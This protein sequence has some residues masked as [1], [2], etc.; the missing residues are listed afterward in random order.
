M[1]WC[2]QAIRHNLNR[3]WPN[4]KKTKDVPMPQFVYQSLINVHVRLIEKKIVTLWFGA[5]RR[6]VIFLGTVDSILKRKASQRL[7]PH[8][9]QWFDELNQPIKFR[10]RWIIPHHRKQWVQLRMHT[11]SQCSPV[12]WKRKTP[13]QWI[14][15]VS[16]KTYAHSQVYH[17]E[18]NTCQ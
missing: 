12:W 16:P 18:I 17:I 2:H 10:Y 3:C 9:F 13:V 8:N 5:N 4:F 15:L 6:G 1:I 7:K 14:V 11:V